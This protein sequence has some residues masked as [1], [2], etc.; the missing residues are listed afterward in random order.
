MNWAD[1]EY[2]IGRGL[3]A[4]RHNRGSQYQPLIRALIETVLPELLTGVTGSTFPNL[5][6]DQILEAELPELSPSDQLAI[7]TVIGSL[8]E[9]IALNEKLN[10]ALEATAAAVF[11]SWFVDFDP[12]VAKSEGRRPFGMTDEIAALFPDRFAPN[13]LPEGWKP[14]DLSDMADVL[15]GQSPPG[16]SYNQDRLGTLFF[17][18]RTD[19]GNRFPS[20]RLFTTAPSRMGRQ[21]DILV[22]VRAPV[23]DVNIV[24]EHCCIGRGLGAVRSKDGRQSYIYYLLRSM[25]EAFEQFEGGGTVFGSISGPEFRGLKIVVPDMVTMEAFEDLVSV[26]DARILLNHRQNVALRNLRDAI[27]PGLVSG[28]LQI[29]DAQQELRPVLQASEEVLSH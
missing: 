17:Q 26:L 8:D 5:S 28:E 12:V 16:E 29:K 15:M 7:S 18:G 22:S 2:V 20:E 9:R 10:S 1:Q 6:R 25:R 3:A 27:L 21:G 14:G 11:K 23:G 19:F 13:G 24:L 4:I